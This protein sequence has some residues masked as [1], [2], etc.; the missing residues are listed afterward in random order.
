MFLALAAEAALS[1]A[2]LAWELKDGMNTL[3]IPRET[4]CEPDADDDGRVGT[5]STNPV[6]VHLS[7]TDVVALAN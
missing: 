1:S 6:G 2:A 5:L 7:E 3:P 4:G